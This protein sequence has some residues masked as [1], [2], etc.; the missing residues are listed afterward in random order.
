[1]GYM[2]LPILAYFIR[3]WRDLQLAISLPSVGLLITWCYLP[4]SP[5]WLIRKGKWGQAEYI[6]HK[7][8][9]KNE[10]GQNIPWN[11]SEM[12]RRVYDKVNY[13]SSWI[14]FF[15]NILELN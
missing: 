12:I 13:F 11:F 4:E 6:L 10:D 7:A 1:M 15:L 8:A 14:T 9:Q 5:R 3:D 2:I